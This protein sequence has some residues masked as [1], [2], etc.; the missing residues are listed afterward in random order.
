MTGKSISSRGERR[1]GWDGR[2]LSE[3]SRDSCGRRALLWTSGV[4]WVLQHRWGALCLG[5]ALQSP[6]L[7]Q[8]GAGDWTDLSA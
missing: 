8:L 5:R 7:S 4:L 1:G 6:A 2:F 3:G